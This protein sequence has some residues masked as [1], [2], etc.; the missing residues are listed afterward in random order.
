MISGVELGKDKRTASQ[1]EVVASSKSGGKLEIWLDDL[2]T[3]KLIATIPITATGEANNW[4][5]F[6]KALKNVS[7]HHDVFVKFPAGA[8]E[9]VFIHSIR[10]I[11]F[12]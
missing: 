6:K 9:A 12:P 5:A 4:K 10:F 1:V 3:G 7:G 11:P 8:G 2:T